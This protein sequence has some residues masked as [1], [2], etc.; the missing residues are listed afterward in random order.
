M[1]K[2]LTAFVVLF[3]TSA[4]STDMIDVTDYDSFEQAAVVAKGNEL[5]GHVY[6][7]KGFYMVEDIQTD[8]V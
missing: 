8:A 3:T 1:I 4:H 7:P 6:V 5:Y 2:F